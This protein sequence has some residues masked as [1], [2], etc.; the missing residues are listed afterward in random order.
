MAE[1]IDKAITDADID[2]IQSLIGV[3]INDRPLKLILGD[4]FIE[5]LDDWNKTVT[6]RRAE[7]FSLLIL[8]EFKRGKSSVINAVL[9]QYAAPVNAEPETFTINSIEYGKEP[10][11]KAVLTDGIKV[12]LTMKDSLIET[13]RRKNLKEMT[14]GFISSLE[15]IEV[16]NNSEF[17]KDIR[18]ID[19][20]GLSDLDMF[21][22]QIKEYLNHADA[23]IYVASALSPLSDSEKLFLEDYINPQNFSKLFVLVNMIDAMETVDDAEKVV[24][25]IREL[26]D[27]IVPG[28][29]IYGISALDETARKTGGETADKDFS[30]YYRDQFLKF[31]TELRQGIALQKDTIR[32]SRIASMLGFMI[33][34]T[35]SQ[36]RSLYETL[37]L[38]A[39]DLELFSQNFDKECDSLSKILEEY[40]PRVTLLAKESHQQAQHFIYEFFGLLRAEILNCKGAESGDLDKYFYPYLIEKITQGYSK[41][42]EYH[43]AIIKNYAEQI[44][45]DITNKFELIFLGR[46]QANINRKETMGVF[47][48]LVSKSALNVFAPGAEDEYPQGSVAIIKDNIKKKRKTDVVT[49]VLEQYDQIRDT[50]VGDLNSAYELIEKN[51]LRYLDGVFKTRVDCGKTTINQALDISKGDSGGLIKKHLGNAVKIVEKCGGILAKIEE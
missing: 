40:K 13:L 7:P 4:E 36:I 21:D 5:S 2:K 14:A 3:L 39:K 1:N 24:Q 26:C 37:D 10:A 49:T 45:A 22:T 6:Q 16:T 41:C 8:G 27:D 50:T 34:N 17:L 25:R 38:D 11:I 44:N 12:D 19:T 32:N 35:V 28:V 51:A 31:E 30:G 42:L 18:I 48:S 20:P 46:D 15:R 33:N 9:G 47:N 23:V 43:R 29:H